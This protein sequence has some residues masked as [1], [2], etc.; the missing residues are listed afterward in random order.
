[1][2]TITECERDNA[3]TIAKAIQLEGDIQQKLMKGSK[4]KRQHLQIMERL[5][6]MENLSK[7]KNLVIYGEQGTNLMANLEAFKM[8]YG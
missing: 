1:M 3:E 5:T 8:V 2:K 6:A 7:N 4:K